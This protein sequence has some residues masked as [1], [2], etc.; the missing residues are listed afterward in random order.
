MSLALERVPMLSKSHC[1]TRGIGLGRCSHR[2]RPGHVV[3]LERRR[4][5][6]ADVLGGES[7]EGNGE[8]EAE[9]DLTVAMIL[10]W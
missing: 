3:A 5:A 7:C 8:V 4:E 2:A 9:S 10:E 1:Q 6:L